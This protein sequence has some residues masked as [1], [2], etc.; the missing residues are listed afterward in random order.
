MG[1]MNILKE[2]TKDWKVPTP[3]HT[4]IFGASKM[5]AIG[6]IKEGT[7]VAIKF[8]TP[9]SFDRRNRT[10]VELKGKD[11]AALDLTAVK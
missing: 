10:F 3:N 8:N 4:Y 7:T 2:T 11:L 6:Y 9:Q 1:P 5:K